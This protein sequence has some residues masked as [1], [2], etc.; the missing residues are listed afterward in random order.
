MNRFMEFNP[1]EREILRILLQE[2]ANAVSQ[3]AIT[4]QVRMFEYLSKI[5]ALEA[6][7]K[8]A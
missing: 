6:E 2:H 8:N 1:E 7:V 5:E 4:Q 3:I